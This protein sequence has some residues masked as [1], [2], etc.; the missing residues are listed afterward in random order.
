[1]KIRIEI[2]AIFLCSAER[3]FKC[4][5]LGDATKF[6]NGYLF[7]PPVIGFE[8]DETW[9]RIGGIRYPVT[10]GNFFMPQGRIFTDKILERDEGKMWKWMIDDFKVPLMFFAEK[11]IGEWKV[12]P[13][14]ENKMRVK[15]S[16]TFYSKNRFYHLFT[17]VFVHIQ[18][19]GMMKKALMGM[20]KMAE[21]DEE[22]IDDKELPVVKP[23]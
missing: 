14:S 1:M 17:V 4:P 2:A 20:S 8:E 10:D 13:V 21:S 5:I 19:K 16:Y 9:G 23:F 11:A 12:I 22:F 18:W 7:Q 6:L 15:Y 3:A